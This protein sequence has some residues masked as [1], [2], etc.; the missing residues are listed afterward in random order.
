MKKLIRLEARWGLAGSGAV[1][2]GLVGSGRVG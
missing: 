2:F 1:R